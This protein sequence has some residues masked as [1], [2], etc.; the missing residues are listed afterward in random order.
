MKKI[1]VALAALVVLLIAALV[2]VVI[3]AVNIGNETTKEPTATSQATATTAGDT[4]PEPQ[5]NGVVEK[6]ASELIS[7][8]S[9]YPSRDQDKYKYGT[10]M[11]IS[12]VVFYRCRIGNGTFFKTL[13]PSKNGVVVH[14]QFSLEPPDAWYACSIEAGTEITIMG[15]YWGF[16]R[17]AGYIFISDAVLLSEGK[18]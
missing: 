5:N 7:E 11:R 8:F 4:S 15:E 3:I 2:T 14:V 13:G 16:S 9:N 12:G 10:V 18:K 6:T 1:V 17:G